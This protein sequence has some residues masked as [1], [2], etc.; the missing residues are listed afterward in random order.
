MKYFIMFFWLFVLGSFL[1]F[2]IE[3]IWCMIRWRKF[4]SRKGLIYGHFIPIYGLAGLF[5]AVVIELLHI[6]KWYIL[7]L[8]TFIITGIVEY[9]SS[10]F[11]EKILGTLSWDYSDMKFN[12]HGRVN[13]IYLLGFSIFGVLWCKFYTKV[14]E[15]FEKLV[16]N[17]NLFVLITMLLFA[18]M[19]Y[20]CFI[21][22]VATYRQK[23]RRNGIEAKNRFEVWLD[24]KYTDDYLKKVYANA[25]VVEE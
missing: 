21:S 13:L 11:Q 7:F 23:Q 6:K 15:I 8:V 16:K 20:N 9:F 5:I 4:E 14:F 3:T 24:K 12:L 22:F 10:L 2:L 1:G 17:E 25:K 19:I 18:F